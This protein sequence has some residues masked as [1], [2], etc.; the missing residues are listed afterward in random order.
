MAKE[1]TNTKHLKKHKKTLKLTQLQQNVVVGTIL[2]DGCLIVSRSNLSARLQIRHCIKHKNYVEWKY[3]FFKDWVLTKPRFD[4]HNNSWYFRTLSHTSLMEIRQ[5]F[6]KEKKLIPGNLNTLLVSPLSL[7]IWFMDDGNGF[8]HY[9]GLRIST[10]AF[11]Q[12]GNEILQNC[13]EDNFK[14]K[15]SLLTDCKGHQL[16]FPKQS[17]KKLYKMI[18]PYI[19]PCMQYKF[20]TLTP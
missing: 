12:N 3:Q 14:L 19:I 10:Y 20:A 7:A 17:A 9:D 6:Y 13:L 18:K 8:K 1:A 5:L 11:G 4:K 16:L 15:T 2:G